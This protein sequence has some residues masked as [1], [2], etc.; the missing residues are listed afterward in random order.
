MQHAPQMPVYVFWVEPSDAKAGAR[1]VTA[2]NY[3]A[4]RTAILSS[5]SAGAFRSCELIDVI[6]GTRRVL[7]PDSHDNV[8]IS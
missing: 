6:T 8:R 1:T 4:A 3:Q 5:T 2:P 7:H